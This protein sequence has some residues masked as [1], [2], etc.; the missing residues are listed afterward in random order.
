MC[1]RSGGQRYR[2]LI[3]G[4]KLL[5]DGFENPFVRVFVLENEE[6]KSVKGNMLRLIRFRLCLSL[7]LDGKEEKKV[8][9]TKAGG[10]LVI[11]VFIIIV[12]EL[13]NAFLLYMIIPKMAHILVRLIIIFHKCYR[14]FR[15]KRETLC[16]L[17]FF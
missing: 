13:N 4:E 17:L 9:T 1:R 8:R 6:L 16:S 3:I 11:C 12:V 14:S 5:M 2:R 15:T 10:A 7:D